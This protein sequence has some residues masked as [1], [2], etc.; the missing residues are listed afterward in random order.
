VPENPASAVV[1]ISNTSG[2]NASSAATI[3]MGGSVAGECMYHLGNCGSRR[4]RLKFVLTVGGLVRVGV[5][6]KGS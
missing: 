1:P 2:S 5:D 6:G 4:I 3:T